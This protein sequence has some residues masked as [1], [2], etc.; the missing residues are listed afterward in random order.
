MRPALPPRR[1][2]LTTEQDPARTL[3]WHIDSPFPEAQSANA[4]L[5]RYD[6]ANISDGRARVVQLH[7]AAIEL[8]RFAGVIRSCFGPDADGLATI[9]SVIRDILLLAMVIERDATHISTAELTEADNLADLAEIETGRASH[10]HTLWESPPED[11]ALHL[12]ATCIH[13]P[14]APSA[15]RETAAA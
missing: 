11:R 5:D 3:S 6:Q 14:G 8:G 10:A 1:H 7:A 12:T 9:E 13:A 2:V 15:R 4:H